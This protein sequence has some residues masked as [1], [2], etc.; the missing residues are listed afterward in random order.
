[1][2]RDT[3]SDCPEKM[4]FP[5]VQAHLM[6][7]TR[8]FA[9]GLLVL[10]AS[11]NSTAHGHVVGENYVWLNID[12]T[13]VSGRFEFNVLD[14]TK[15]LSI[16][17]NGT[18]EAA[19]MANLDVVR[20]YVREHF[21]LMANGVE[22]P[23][24]I[25]SATFFDGEG[26]WGQYHFNSE[27]FDIPDEIVIRND[28]MLADDA[29]HRSLLLTEYN[30]KTGEEYGLV[31]V[32]Q[33]F[34][35][36]NTEQTLDLLNIEQILGPFGFIWQGILHIW[37][38]IDHILFLIVL[39]LPA[40][41]LRKD[42][43]WQPVDSFRAALWNVL[44]IVTVFTIAHSITLSLAALDF[45]QLPSRLV[46]ST[47]ALSIILVG[48]N[49]LFPKVREGALWIIFFFGLF[50]GLGF[51]SVMG[52]LPFRMLD[53][54]WVVLGFNVGVELGQI[55]IVAAVFPMIFWLRKNRF[56]TPVILKGG[57]IALCV[58]ASYWFVERAFAL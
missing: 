57:T 56:Y 53:L 32:V 19:V 18:S 45:V 31:C 9:V 34:S 30:K 5:C 39:L 29:F 11:V 36:A 10:V 47:I 16:E 25:R 48:I 14:L 15:K 35:A 33:I 13:R 4:Y 43:V 55:A 28:L 40:V 27:D 44:R 17:V 20:D 21:H 8:L 26:E 22:I 41:L 58:V 6:S 23:I 3:L 42:G 50:H 54:I 38:G 37:I 12:E 1:M 7:L 49:V 24:T 52:D 46:E 51:A 2:K